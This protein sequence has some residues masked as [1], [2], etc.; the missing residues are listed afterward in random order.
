[1][2]LGLLRG[3]ETVSVD[4]TVMERP[5]PIDELA[6]LADPEKSAV[7]RLGIIGI[8]VDDA[9]ADLLPRLRMS[10]GVFVAA[11][12]EV[13]SGNEVPLVAGDVIH[14]VNELRREER[15]RFARARGRCSR[16]T[17][18]WSCRSNA[19]ASCCSLICQPLIEDDFRA[20]T[21]SAAWTERF[22]I[23]LDG[24]IDDSSAEHGGESHRRDGRANL[25]DTQGHGRPGVGPPDLG[26]A[27]WRDDPQSC[28][29][30][31]Q[32]FATISPRVGRSRPAERVA[33]LLH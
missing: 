23:P 28:P 2:A 11:R 5:H 12:T 6:G 16:P 18:S 13:S 4:V 26:E 7:P 32:P 27:G 24:M 22:G 33:S 8:D 29:G 25:I 3:A 10:S 20:S 9:T 14:A 1:M 31:A 15:R 17:A 21:V 30:T 19:T